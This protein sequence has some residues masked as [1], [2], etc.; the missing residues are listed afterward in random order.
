MDRLRPG[1]NR[2]QAQS[3]METNTGTM[4]PTTPGLNRGDH[5]SYDRILRG[6]P[7]SPLTMAGD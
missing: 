4:N 3:V 1:V 5:G 6:E 7:R 2:I